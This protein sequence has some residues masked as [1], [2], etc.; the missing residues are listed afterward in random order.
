MFD[1]SLPD[2]DSEEYVTHFSVKVDP[3]QQ[4]LRIDKFLL[5]KIQ[6]ASRTR[7]QAA[8]EA[9]CIF[10]GGKPVKSSYKIKPGDQISLALPGTP[11]GI[12]EV[13]P[14]EMPLD[15][16]YEDEELLILNKPAG[17]V[18]HPAVGHYSGTLVNGLTHY[19]QKLPTGKNGDMRPGLVHRIDKDT[20]G[21][22][23]I[24]KT[25]TAMTHLANQFFH[26][27]I[28]REYQALAWGCPD[29]EEGE[30][31]G[32]LGRS[33]RDRKMMALYQEEDM[34]KWSKTHYKVCE[35]LHYVSL[36]TCR[37]E[38]GRTHQIRC[39]FKAIG[40]PL[41]ADEMYGGNVRVKGLSSGSYNA[42]VDKRLRALGRQA[43]HA[44]M[45]GFEHPRTHEKMKF[46][47]PWPADFE[48][49]IQDW[50]K[51]VHARQRGEFPDLEPES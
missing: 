24:A 25:E 15:I 14:E 5:Y 16:I 8:A 50:R 2:S 10:V 48:Q 34:G 28:N 35:N 38:T 7:I 42:F 49:C 17:L 20:S 1:D 40:H 44:G 9:D 33:T 22:L 23:V 46:E 12:T 36:I 27:T 45:I 19:F 39:H 32:Y 30:I 43:L 4:P 13:I 31:S 21:L 37:L 26:H 18:V 41:F 47:V 29:L 6:N 11:K 3:G 51:Y